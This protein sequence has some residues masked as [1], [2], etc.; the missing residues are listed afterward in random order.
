MTSFLRLWLL[1][2]TSPTGYVDALGDAPAP[3]W[4]FFGQLIRGLLDALLLYL[5]LYL[6]GRQPSRAS[7]LSLIP[8]ESQFGAF[9]AL[10]PAFYLMQWLFLVA[11]VH[12]LLR[13]IGRQSDIDAI[14]NIT[15]MTALVVGA[16]ILVWDWVWLALGWRDPVALGIS[17]LVIDI[18]GMALIVAAFKRVL[19]IPVRL[20]VLLSIVW[21]AVGI[22]LA[23][24]LVPAP[25]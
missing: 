1:G 9:A 3:H 13:L 2:Y 10:G 18:W 14:M 20:G 4:G 17:H 5:P 12:L 15:G 19:G 25:V 16:V 24:V 7:V 23:M 22:P 21:V 11:L 8:T 6:M